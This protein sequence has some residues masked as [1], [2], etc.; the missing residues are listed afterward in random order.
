VAFYSYARGKIRAV[1]TEEM[2][3]WSSPKL[4][5]MPE[6]HLALAH[7]NFHHH[8][9]VFPRWNPNVHAVE[10][11][12]KVGKQTIVSSIMRD[13]ELGGENEDT[14]TEVSPTDFES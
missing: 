7:H 4:P 2:C 8:P 10:S 5:D 9:G 1:C 6:A 12:I 11:A 13:L 3:G 14:S